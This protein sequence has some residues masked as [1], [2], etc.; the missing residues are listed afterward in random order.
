MYNSN[1]KLQPSSPNLTEI[2][3]DIVKNKTDTYTCFTNKLWAHLHCYD[4][5]QFTEIYGEYIIEYN[6]FLGKQ[7]K[8]YFERKAKAVYDNLTHIHDENHRLQNL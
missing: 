1:K 6:Y 5:D 2:T 8:V 3:Y 7:D 4:I